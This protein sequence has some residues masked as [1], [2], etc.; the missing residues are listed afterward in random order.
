MFGLDL[1]FLVFF[2]ACFVTALSG[3]IFT[4]G[5]WYDSLDKPSWQPPS[6]L[7]GPVWSVLYIMIA[8]SGW[9]VWQERDMHL[10]TVPMVAY[11]IQLVLNFMWSALFFGARR[12]D[13]ALFEVVLLW[14]SILATI[15]V[16]LPISATAAYL[17]LPY[18]AWVSFAAFLNLTMLRL[19]P[20]RGRGNAA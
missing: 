3:A 10:M 4:P 13:Y 9:L 11:S 14:L 19:N 1:S 18:L 2:G 16:F 12:M 5:E 7:F 6:W 15:L 20:V 17:L 8:V